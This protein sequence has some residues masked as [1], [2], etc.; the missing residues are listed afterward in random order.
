[1]IIARM[2][3]HPFNPAGLTYISGGFNISPR[4]GSILYCAIV[5]YNHPT[6]SGL[7]HLSSFVNAIIM[8]I[9]LFAFEERIIALIIFNS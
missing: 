3:T 2:I 7:C 1:M 6:P 9:Y 4:R 8:Y 5:C